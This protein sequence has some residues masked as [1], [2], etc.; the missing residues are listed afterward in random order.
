MEK[1]EPADMNQLIIDRTFLWSV[2]RM[3]G[4]LSHVV[5]KCENTTEGPA[6]LSR[7]VTECYQVCTR[8]NAGCVMAPHSPQQSI[9]GQRAPR[10]AL[11]SYCSIKVLCSENKVQLPVLRA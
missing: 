7:G 8:R 11:S 6:G 9:L 1:D 3:V 2:R 4:D 10:W 5:M